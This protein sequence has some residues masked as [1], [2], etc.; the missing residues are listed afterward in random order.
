MYQDPDQ[1]PFTSPFVA[2]RPPP[3]TGSPDMKAA[4]SPPTSPASHGTSLLS[5][6]PQTPQPIVSQAATQAPL[7]AVPGSST[8]PGSLSLSSDAGGALPASA[9]PTT[10]APG[11]AATE[12]ESALSVQTGDVEKQKKGHRR[13]RSL[14]GL[15]P[16]L[17]TKPK[18]SQSQLFEVV[19][20]TW[21]PSPLPLPL[22][23]CL[24]I[25]SAAFSE[26]ME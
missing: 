1:R 11:A 7:S 10:A 18:R 5:N 2:D 23:L 13:G 3:D 24:R 19:C 26:P 22:P 8:A 21:P 16:T 9:A 12:S 15:I 17:K 20:H 25:G 6:A 4:P 14:T